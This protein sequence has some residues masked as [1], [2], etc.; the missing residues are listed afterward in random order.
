M[1]RFFAIR[2][3]RFA[4]FSFAKKAL[5]RFHGFFGHGIHGRYFSILF[6]RFAVFS[7]AKKTLVGFHGFFGRTIWFEPLA[8][9][10][11]FFVVEAVDFVEEDD[12]AFAF[13]ATHNALGEPLDVFGDVG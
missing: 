11:E 13:G 3:Q 1:K 4:V 2:I 9:G 12:E 5:V 6:I 8:E 10:D 7:F